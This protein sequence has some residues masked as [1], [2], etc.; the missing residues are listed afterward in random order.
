MWGRPGSAPDVPAKLWAG[1][2]SRTAVRPSAR[3][4][5]QA[6][7]S[8]AGQQRH[9]AGVG[10]RPPAGRSTCWSRSPATLSSRGLGADPP[11]LVPLPATCPSPPRA[12]PRLVPLPASCRF[13]I[14]A[15]NPSGRC[16]ARPERCHAR[17]CQ[18]R[19]AAPMSD[20]V[21]SCRQAIATGWRSPP[22]GCGLQP[23]WVGTGGC[24]ASLCRP[25]ASGQLTGIR[26]PE[27][28]RM[29]GN[30]P[31]TSGGTDPRS[32]PASGRTP[33]AHATSERWWLLRPAGR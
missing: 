15:H 18:Q 2:R 25:A 13:P 19:P 6:Q 31:A 14:A 10:G 32:D 7:P 26:R 27:A 8:Q 21:P 9:P 29:P 33:S 24:Q 23:R 22:A 30:S 4:S 12:A 1:Q 3:P 20:R 11:R 17:Q 28:D 5:A 16:C